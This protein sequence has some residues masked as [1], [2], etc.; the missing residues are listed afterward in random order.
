MG[1]RGVLA[2]ICRRGLFLAAR[3]LTER[4]LRRRTVVFA[5]H[6]DDETLGCGGT[7][8]RKRALGTPVSV[9]FMTDGSDANGNRRFGFLA[10]ERLREIRRAEA[11]RACAALG[12]A[13]ADVHFLDFEDGSLTALPPVAVERVAALLAALDAEEVF[14]PY[15]RDG[16]PDHDATNAIVC[17]ALRRG[18]ARFVNEYPVWCWNRWPLTGRAAPGRGRNPL[19]RLR[20]R[21]QGVRLLFASFRTRVPVAAAL[22]AKRAALAAHLSQTTRLVPDARWLR[23]QEIEG[24]DWLRCFF[25]RYELFM[26]YRSG[27][28]PGGDAPRAQE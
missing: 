27:A 18:P 4:E 23:L 25:Q 1:L 28:A 26:R 21:L 3:P 22:D 2:E 7:I 11:V 16:H 10:P 15:R 14:I 12:V 24:G 6:Q 5:P 9:V 20:R 17:T 8:A 19:R 13:E